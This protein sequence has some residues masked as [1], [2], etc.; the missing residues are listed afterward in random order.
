MQVLF[1]PSGVVMLKVGES[2]ANKLCAPCGNFN[3]NVSDDL[4]L[5]SG[6]IVGSIAEVIDAWKARNFLGCHAS[7]IV[8]A[9]L[10]APLVPA[11]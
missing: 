11:H 3:G 8:R 6:K 7:N 4:R 10:E 1:S 9:D 5:P 2:L